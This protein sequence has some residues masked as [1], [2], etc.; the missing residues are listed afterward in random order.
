MSAVA[1]AESIE[2]RE[3]LDDARRVQLSHQLVGFDRMLAIEVLD[4]LRARVEEWNRPGS[5]GGRQRT[6]RAH[7]FLLL[8]ESLAG[9]L[10]LNRS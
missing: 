2:E 10:D 3:K 6:E 8:A 4:H 5:A 9:E 1:L 7:S